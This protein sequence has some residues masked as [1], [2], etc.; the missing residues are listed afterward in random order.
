MSQRPLR[1]VDPI[2]DAPT[3]TPQASSAVPCYGTLHKVDQG[4]VIAGRTKNIQIYPLH[5]EFRKCNAISLT[6]EEGETLMTKEEVG[7]VI[8]AL[9]KVQELIVA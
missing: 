7:E 5:D 9:Q 8:A 6:V 3:P 2:L 4:C 1:T